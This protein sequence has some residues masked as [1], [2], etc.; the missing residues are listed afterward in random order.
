[1]GRQARLFVVSGPSGAGKGTLLKRVREERP[2]LHLTVSATTRDPREGEV[3]G[4]SYHF[5]GENEFLQLVNE[6]A[7]LEWAEVH[8]HHYGTL[9]REVDD[10]ISVGASVILEIDVQGA[11]NVRRQRPDAVLVFVEPPSAEELERRLRSRGTEDE[12]QILLRLSNARKEMELA[13]RYDERIV[14]DDLE[15]AVAQLVA[16]ID[17]YEYEGGNTHH[18][19]HEPRD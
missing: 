12:D 18:G 1:M 11:F 3:D 5:M 9:C 10:S 2:E 6:D 4:V 8:G 13:Q 7:F 14:N 19:N 16:L 17:R 15:T